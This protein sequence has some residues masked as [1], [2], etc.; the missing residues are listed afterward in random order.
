MSEDNLFR[1]LLLIFSICVLSIVANP[2]TKTVDNS[3]SDI[4]NYEEKLSCIMDDLNRRDSIGI[5]DKIV[6][7]EK[8]SDPKEKENIT[9]S[10]KET[11]PLIR[12]IDEFFKSRRLQITLPTDGSSADYFGRAL[13]EKN[14]KF[15]LKNLIH[16]G[17]ERKQLGII[18]NKF[19]KKLV[20]RIIKPV[21]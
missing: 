8:I 14:F 11:D 19:I 1:R 4:T 10:D 16:G 20:K 12:R 2:L 15:E 17:S 7:L 13:G 3:Q 21:N 18:F 5:V 6:S 9:N